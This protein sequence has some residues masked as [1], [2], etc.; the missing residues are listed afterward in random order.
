MTILEL[1]YIISYDNLSLN[2]RQVE[3][4]H[5]Q[6]FCFQTLKDPFEIIEKLEMIC[7]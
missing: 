6:K 3:R 1:F 4:F 2:I 7:H 5:V